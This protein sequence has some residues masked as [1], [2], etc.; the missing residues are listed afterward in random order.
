[1]LITCED[2]TLGYEN[3]AVAEHISFAVNEGDYL[4]V[5]GEN[6]S[7]KSTLVKTLLSLN[8]P[9]SGKI[10]R[11]YRAGE[12]GYLPQQTPFQKDFPAVVSEIV[13]SGRLGTK[14][15]FGVYTKADKAAARDNL[16]KLGIGDLYD[17]PYRA[18]SGGQQQRVLLA[19][20]LCA[21]RKL[22]LLDEPTAGLDTETTAKFYHLVHELN[23]RDGSAVIMV[24]HD[25]PAALG[26]ASHVL[27]L[28][29]KPFFGTAKEYAARM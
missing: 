14:G 28:G 12:I 22:L 15:L 25:I 7:G 16:E 29:D 11:T 3:E 8:K 6:G 10:T 1:M 24:T 9:L 13:L 26:Y 18:L 21:S 19:R 20:A 4:C 17:R 2:V 27:H 23:T 5:V